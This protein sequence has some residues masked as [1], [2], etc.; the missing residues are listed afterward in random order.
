MNVFYL[1]N[2]NNKPTNNVP[3]EKFFNLSKNKSVN[4]KKSNSFKKK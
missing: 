4:T 3:K 2:M 1:K